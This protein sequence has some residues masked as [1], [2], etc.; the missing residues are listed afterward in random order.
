MSLPCEA[1]HF[2]PGCAPT[3][4]LLGTLE[5]LLRASKPAHGLRLL[6]DVAAFVNATLVW[7]NGAP[8][9]GS[10]RAAP[11]GQCVSGT[12]GSSS[13]SRILCAGAKDAVLISASSPDAAEPC[14]TVAGSSSSS[15]QP[16]IDKPDCHGSSNGA[17]NSACAVDNADLLASLA[18]L[19]VTIGHSMNCWGI[20]LSNHD[21]DSQRLRALPQCVVPSCCLVAAQLLHLAAQ[22][23]QT[24][25]PSVLPALQLAA[26]AQCL[27]GNCGAL[28]ESTTAALKEASDP[29][30]ETSLDCMDPA[31]HIVLAAAA[32]LRKAQPSSWQSGE[33]HTPGS[34]QK[35]AADMGE[36]EV[37]KSSS[38]SSSGGGGGGNPFQRCDK[39]DLLLSMATSIQRLCRP[40]LQLVGCSHPRCTNLSGPSAQGLV[41]GHKGVV[42]SGCRVARYCSPA[43]QKADWPQHRHVCRRL[44]V[45]C[46]H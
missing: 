26:A 36:A 35:A 11:V 23:L 45:L 7:M 10:D 33:A 32:A 44:A 38:S 21:S 8:V 1:L 39:S 41:A 34:Q 4:L 31:L 22:Q 30:L 43:C 28:A 17:T 29:Q 15:S 13:S 3:P 24:P 16:N 25:G 40:R 12:G 14:N 5:A 42:C 19:A 2:A 46:A 27:A 18:S 6:C 37:V 9:D 20:P